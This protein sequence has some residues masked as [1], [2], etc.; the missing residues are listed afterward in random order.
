MIDYEA[1]REDLKQE[2]LGAF[3]V[4]DFGGALIETSYIEKANPD[5]LIKLA[6]QQGIDIHKYDSHF[7]QYE[8]V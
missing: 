2:S 3:F 5:E 6:K 8:D 7:V 1:L 4:G